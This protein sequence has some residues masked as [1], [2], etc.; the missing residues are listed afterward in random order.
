MNYFFQLMEKGNGLEIFAAAKFV[1][2]PLTFLAAVIEIEHRRDRI[3][4]QT[5]EMKLA[6]PVKRIGKQ[7]VAH[8]IPVI[9]EDV[10]APVRMFALAGIGV[11]V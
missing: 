8:F 2:H 11:L 5:I 7:E 9:V 1:R 6:Q 3:H 4:P 10:C